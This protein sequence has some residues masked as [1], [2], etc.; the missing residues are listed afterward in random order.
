MPNRS[1][2]EVFEDHLRLAEEGEVELDLERNYTDDTV[3][4]T[5]FGVL[6]GVRE[7]YRLLEEQLPNPRY[8]Y[9]TQQVH[10]EI[11]FLEWTA[12]SERAWVDDGV[13]TFLIREG[14][15]RVQ[16][17]HYTIHRKQDGT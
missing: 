2:R 10:G 8:T 17:I 7:A 5:S 15:I 9:V 12:D 13:D 14:K 1:T 3:L 16:T 11:A 6:Y 4:L